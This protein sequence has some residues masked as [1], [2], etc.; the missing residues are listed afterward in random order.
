[1]S[2]LYELTSTVAY[3]QSLLEEGEID[4]QTYKDS[5][6][7]MCVDGK[8]EN[9]FKVMRNLERK[10][11][12]FAEEIKRMT[13]RKKTLDN[14]VQRLKDSVLN[15]LLVSETKNMDAGV[16]SVGLRSSKSLK[17]WDDSHIPPEFLIPQKPK[18]DGTALKDAIKNGMVIDGV[19]IVE[20]PYIVVR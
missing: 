11:D 14:S 20:K 19:E 12:A 7:S 6:E 13:A 17:V 15:Y 18:V 16:F 5:V 4:E 8:V 2:S 9:I 3:L 1:M 10:A